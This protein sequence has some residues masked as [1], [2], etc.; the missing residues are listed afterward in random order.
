MLLVRPDELKRPDEQREPD[1][2]PDDPESA[3]Q[4]GGR[5]ADGLGCDFERVLS[6]VDRAEP[7]AEVLEDR[8]DAVP[9]SRQ[10]KS[11]PIAQRAGSCSGCG[12]D[13]RI[14]TGE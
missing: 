2:D 3:G 4:D 7:V 10:G 5:C 11:P 1:G 13:D 6:L 9:D 8:R 14:R 12:G